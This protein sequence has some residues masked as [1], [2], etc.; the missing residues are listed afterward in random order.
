M[1]KYIDVALYFRRTLASERDRTVD[2]LE[3]NEQPFFISICTIIIGCYFISLEYASANTAIG[4]FFIFVVS[5]I[6]YFILR[7][8][9]SFRFI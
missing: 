3:L 2:A 7:A 4:S 8:G 1:I 5:S 6:R 9:I